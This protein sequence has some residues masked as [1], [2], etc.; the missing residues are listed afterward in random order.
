MANSAS[1]ILAGAT[2]LS[3]VGAA[4]AYSSG[5]FTQ[6]AETEQNGGLLE[7]AAGDLVRTVAASGKLTPAREVDVGAQVSGQLHRIHV[8]EGDLVE[9]GQLLAEIDPTLAQAALVEAE[10]AVDVLRADLDAKAAEVRQANS[11]LQRLRHLADRGVSSAAELDVAVSAIAVAEAGANSLR[12]QIRQA[13]AALQTARANI[14]Y[15]RIV[16]PMAGTVMTVAA[17]EGQT[18]NANNEAPLLLTIADLTRM[19]VEAEV[20]EADVSQLEPGQTTRFTVLGQADDA[21]N[22]RLAQILPEPLV[23]NQVVF[24]RALFE[25]DNPDGRLMD[26]MTAQVFF[27]LETSQGEPLV[28]L[29]AL[30][31]NGREGSSDIVLLPGVDGSV[32]Q[33]RVELGARDEVRAAV[34]DGLEPGEWIF[35]SGAASR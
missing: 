33:R 16:S 24:Y 34:V 11:S 12:A 21:R 23:V 10:A 14:A 32:E 19:R 28:P 35:A 18:L 25:V 9:A 5:H 15:T 6:P 8:E 17:K 22:G 13:E 3:L 2:L 31:N 26:Q 7:V 30:V 29:D 4:A 27:E 1:R 20:S